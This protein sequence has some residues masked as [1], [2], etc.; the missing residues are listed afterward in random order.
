[1]FFLEVVDFFKFFWDVFGILLAFSSLSG[2]LEENALTIRKKK[3]AEISATYQ[4][5][6][7]IF[8]S[9]NDFS[10]KGTMIARKNKGKK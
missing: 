1:M 3:C 10:F 9:E 8:V 2:N 4:K 5:I 7:F 6:D